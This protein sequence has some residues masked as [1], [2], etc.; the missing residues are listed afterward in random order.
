VLLD[1]S[2]VTAQTTALEWHS[3]IPFIR[4]HQQPAHQSCR[5]SSGEATGCPPPLLSHSY[6]TLV[7]HT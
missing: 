5:Q 7:T 1:S 3:Q 6:L 2:G 4:P